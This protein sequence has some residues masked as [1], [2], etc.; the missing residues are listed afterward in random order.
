MR[1]DWIE[2]GSV[3]WVVFWGAVALDSALV[4][5]RTREAIDQAVDADPIVEIYEGPPEPHGRV[6]RWLLWREPNLGRLRELCRRAEVL[7]SSAP[8]I[9][10]IGPPL[11]FALG[12][13]R[14]ENRV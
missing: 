3:L 13:R 4:Y 10:L 8:W 2:T 1:R 12:V 14:D 9:A 11:F 6:N 5:R 7:K